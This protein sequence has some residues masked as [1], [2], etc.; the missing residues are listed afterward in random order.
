[1]GVSYSTSR[2]EQAAYWYL[3]LQEPEVSAE[4][5]QAAMA[6]QADSDNRAA[7][8][9]VEAFWRAWPPKPSVARASL[10]KK[11]RSLAWGAAAAVLAAV[12]LSIGLAIQ[13]QRPVEST[14]REYATA[15]GEVRTVRLDDG[16]E[17]TLGGATSLRTSFSTGFRRIIMSDG[18]ALFH[19]AKDVSRPFIVNL[20]NGSAQALGTIF[21]VHLGPDEATIS[22]VEGVVQVSPPSWQ[23]GA[24]AELAAG[25][26]VAISADGMPG[27]MTEFNLLDVTGWR[28][29]R[30]VFIDRTLRS[31]VADLNRYS[32]AQI[33]LAALE[34]ESKRVSGAVKLGETEDWLRA[35]GPIVG[36][37]VVQSNHGTALVS[38]AKRDVSK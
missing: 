37:D 29:G 33:T 2:E 21:N 24:S 26:Q 6:W 18:E 27:P 14:A 38:K 12:A 31:V 34:A 20:P 10:P 5:I 25:T 28:S 1:M 7:F 19:V 3:K 15:I 13:H 16:S 4:E 9:R 11:H 17:V 35:L 30:L 32:S 23:G 22:V 36:V 8:E